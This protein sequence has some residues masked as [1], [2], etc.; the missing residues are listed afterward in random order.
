MTGVLSVGSDAGSDTRPAKYIVLYEQGASPAAVKAAVEQA[1][2]RILRANNKIGVATAISANPRFLGEARAH[3]LR[4]RASPG[5]SRS[6]GRS[7]RCGR[8]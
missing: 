2:G 3:R 1:K 5:T 7:R 6:G 8:S 4:S